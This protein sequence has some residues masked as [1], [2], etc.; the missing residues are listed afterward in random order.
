MI[1]VEIQDGGKTR[2]YNLPD[3]QR[4][5]WIDFFQWLVE[6]KIEPVIIGFFEIR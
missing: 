2:E 5:S 4:D 3:S 1:I 6:N